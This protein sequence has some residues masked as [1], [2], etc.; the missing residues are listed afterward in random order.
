MADPIIEELWKIKDE[1]AR[2]HGSNIE[3]L[4]D[5]LQS[6]SK[7]RGVPVI[8]LEREAPAEAEA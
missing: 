4:V 8:D 7:A 2:E 1:I 3:T 5:A 6:K